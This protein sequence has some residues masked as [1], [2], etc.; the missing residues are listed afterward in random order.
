VL[1]GGLT[2]SAY[3]ESRHVLISPQGGGFR[4]Q[5]DDALA[6]RGMTRRVMYSIQQ[7]L[8][9]ALVVAESELLV[10]TAERVAH[11]VAKLSSLRVAE[12]PF[13]LPGFDL[14]QVSHARSN[15]DAG[16]VWLRAEIMKVARRLS[17]LRP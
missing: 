13:K 2:L 4:G 11:M 14:K 6:A 12:L 5:I 1:R 9:A 10:T 7:F 3:T 15:E 17:P 16:V 8:V